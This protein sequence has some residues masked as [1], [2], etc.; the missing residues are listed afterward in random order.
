MARPASRPAHRSTPA[1]EEIP[2]PT[3]DNPDN[4]HSR[5]LL[6]SLPTDE[7]ARSEAWAGLDE[8]ERKRRA[9]AAAATHDTDALQALVGAYITLHARAGLRVSAHTRRSYATGVA[10]LIEAWREQSLLH[11]RRD[12]ARVWLRQLERDGASPGTTKVRLAAAR[13]LYKAL[14]W[15]GATDA[16]P[17]GNVKAA[18]DPTAAWDKRQPYPDSDIAK[19]LEAADPLERAIVLLGAHGGLRVSEMCDLRWGDIAGD[20]ITVRNGK[21]AKRRLVATSGS[22]REALAAICPQTGNS[23]PTERTDAVLG[24]LDAD[25][26]RYRM[27]QLCVKSGVKYLGVHALRHSCGTRIVREGGDLDRAARH[28]GH[29]S[30][31]TTRVYAKWS[32]DALERQ[33]TN[34]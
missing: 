6:P 19:L 5:A 32:S 34:W 25:Q 24:G 4:R 8:G 7:L 1:P 23:I 10:M 16:N 11:P 29:A 13:A 15:A 2:V 27:E 30:I 18:H 9:M 26:V 31:E 12:A 14:G 21:G 20:T 3:P 28:L 17:F 22:L 33:L